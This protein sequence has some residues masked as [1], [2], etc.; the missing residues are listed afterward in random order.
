MKRLFL[1]VFVVLASLLFIVIW[2]KS[3]RC[4]WCP[5]VNCLG[6]YNCNQC[7]CIKGPGENTGRC[8]GSEKEAKF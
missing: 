8:Y 1:A 5:D 2:S 6:N 4:I 3:A 7:I